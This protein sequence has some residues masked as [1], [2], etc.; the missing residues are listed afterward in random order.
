MSIGGLNSRFGNGAYLL[1]LM[2]YPLPPVLSISI[3][4]KGLGRSILASISK[5]GTYKSFVLILMR[6]CVGVAQYWGIFIAVEKGP[7]IRV[8][9]PAPESDAR[10][11][12][13][14]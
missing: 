5:Q 7:R 10:Y 12:S 11:P 4:T 6:G 13:G 1:I 9:T 8:Q 3:K 2:G 14:Q